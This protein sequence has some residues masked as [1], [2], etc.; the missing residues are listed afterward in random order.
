MQ[1]Q[2]EGDKTHPHRKQERTGIRHTENTMM[3]SEPRK[4]GKHTSDPGSS[5]GLIFP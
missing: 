5:E 3:W 2:I 4:A 1:S